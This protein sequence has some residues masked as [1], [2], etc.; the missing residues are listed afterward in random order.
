[1]Q[2]VTFFL[3]LGIVISIISI[4]LVY[5]NPFTSLSP[6]VNWDSC[7][8]LVDNGENK[9]NIVFL[10]SE[11]NAKEFSN[12]LFMVE[13][14]SSKKNNFNVYYVDIDPKCELYKN[15]AVFCY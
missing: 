6:N 4:V 2:K 5:I 14:Y 7:K 11:E 10:S 15:T 9:I 13:P 1:M 3:L 8:V 12:Y